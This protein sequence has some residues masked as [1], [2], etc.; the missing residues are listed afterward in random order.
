MLLAL[1]LLQ[2]FLSSIWNLSTFPWCDNVCIGSY[3]VSIYEPVSKPCSCQHTA[4]CPFSRMSW[5]NPTRSITSVF[6]SDFLSLFTP[7]HCSIERHHL[8][9]QDC[10]RKKN[11]WICRPLPMNYTW[12]N[13]PSDAC[14]KWYTHTYWNN[15]FRWFLFLAKSWV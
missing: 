9:W 13:S 1:Q 2:L 8:P 6:M 11:E 15:T 5:H 14:K 4:I 12:F 3:W 10:F 7:R